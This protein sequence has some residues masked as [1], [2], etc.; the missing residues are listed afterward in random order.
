EPLHSAFAGQAHDRPGTNDVPDRA[1][2]AVVGVTNHHAQPLL[3]SPVET[4]VTDLLSPQVGGHQ[5]DLDR[6]GGTGPAVHLQALGT[7]A[8]VDREGD[9]A[10]S[11]GCVTTG[12]LDVRLPA[13][14]SPLADCRATVPVAGPVDR[15][16]PD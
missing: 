3:L 1:G 12:S 16:H 7:P 13:F 5:Q 2:A 8:N 11:P 10:G 14:H 4:P 6:A 15:P 9:P